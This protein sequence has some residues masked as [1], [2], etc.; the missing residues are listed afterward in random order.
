MTAHRKRRDEETH[1]DTA[2]RAFITG[3][4]RPPA[5]SVEIVSL[6]VNAR[7]Q[8]LD[9]VASAILALPGA[10]IHARDP[11]GKLIVVLEAPTQ[12]EIG[13]TSNQISGLPHVLSAVMAFQAT[14]TEPAV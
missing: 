4:W 2:R 1:M 3:S 7:P 14:D 8:H 11:I 13:A 12:G 5:A 10:E 6:V 9:D